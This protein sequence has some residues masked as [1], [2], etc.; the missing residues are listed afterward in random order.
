MEITY[1]RPSHAFC[2]KNIVKMNVF[3]EENSSRNFPDESL[4]Q[5][6]LFAGLAGNLI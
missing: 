4:V 1:F 2:K 6:T 3:Y 5:S